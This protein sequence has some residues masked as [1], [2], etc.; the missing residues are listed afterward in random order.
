MPQQL[1]FIREKAVSTHIYFGCT[2]N[3]QAIINKFISNCP[4]FDD[5]S[6]EIWTCT[7]N[8]SKY[9]CYE[10]HYIITKISEI[11]SYPF[12]KVENTEYFIHDTNFI[13]LTNLLNKLS[14]NYDFKQII[15]NELR[16]K[17]RTYNYIEINK[18]RKN[19]D[20]RYEILLTNDLD[21]FVLNNVFC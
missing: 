7:I 17:A 5:N 16:E 6:H 2:T 18:E 3:L 1:Y 19:D 10:L 14:I 20:D 15:V 9:S 12:K 4:H 21:V 13:N 8:D 11:Y